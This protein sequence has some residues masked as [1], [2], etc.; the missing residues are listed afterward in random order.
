MASFCAFKLSVRGWCIFVYPDIFHKDT[1]CKE[2]IKAQPFNYIEESIDTF[3][4]SHWK[5]Y[6]MV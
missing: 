6:Y 5:L 4:H 1:K 2:N 3:L